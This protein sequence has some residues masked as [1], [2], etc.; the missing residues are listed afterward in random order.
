MSNQTCQLEA[1]LP[2]RHIDRGHIVPIHCASMRPLSNDLRTPCT[3]NSGSGLT[4]EFKV[5]TKNAKAEC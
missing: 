5:F 3:S 2:G 1:C 4:R